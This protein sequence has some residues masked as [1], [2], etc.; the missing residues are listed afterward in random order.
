M[1]ELDLPRLDDD[2]I[3]AKLPTLALGKR[4]MDELRKAQWIEF[5][6]QCVGFDRLREIDRLAP[7]HWTVPSGS[8]LTIRYEPEKPPTLTVRIQEV[9]GLTETPRVGD[10]RIPL[11]LE[12]LGPNYRPQQITND[13]ASFWRNTYPEIKKELRRR[14]PKHAW[15][16]DPLSAEATR[17]GLSPRQ[18]KK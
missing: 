7:S 15:P 3:R 16:D 1:P 14:Y 5:F 2:S 10:H 9:F 12:L 4:S 6:Q 17:S 18:K 13:L 11:N 8:Q